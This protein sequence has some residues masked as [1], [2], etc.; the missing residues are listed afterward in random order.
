MGL[1]FVLLVSREEFYYFEFVQE[2]SSYLFFWGGGGRLA[3]G[4]GFVQVW[5]FCQSFLPRENV[6]RLQ[7]IV[8][9]HL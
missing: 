9:V 2:L 3:W 4:W 1:S 6:T 7:N 5:E 8:E